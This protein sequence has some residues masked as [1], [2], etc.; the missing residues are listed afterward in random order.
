MRGVSNSLPPAHLSK[1]NRMPKASNP[2]LIAL[3][4]S[5]IKMK[6]ARTYS[7]VYKAGGFRVKLYI[8]DKTPEGIRTALIRAGFANIKIE[9]TTSGCYGFARSVT[10]RASKP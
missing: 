5:G 2:L 3:R 4:S 9:T 6:C 7:T 10:I 1:R 8:V